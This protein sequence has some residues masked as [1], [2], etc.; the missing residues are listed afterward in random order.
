MRILSVG[1]VLGAKQITVQYAVRRIRILR[2]EP[3]RFMTA[4][5]MLVGRATAAARSVRQ[6]TTKTRVFALQ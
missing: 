2:P 1:L 5:A 4:C 6:D 3:S